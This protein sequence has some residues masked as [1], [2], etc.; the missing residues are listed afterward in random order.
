MIELKYILY[1]N[2]GSGNHGC[3]A[4]V[5][6][7]QEILGG[8]M[9]IHSK[10]PEED[11]KYGLGEFA[12]IVPA[13]SAVKKDFTYIKSYAKLK[14]FGNYTDMDGLAYL[15]TI[16]QENGKGRLALSVG[17]DNYCYSDQPFYAF[18]NR[19]YRKNGYKTVLWGCSI[20]PDVVENDKI[21]DDLKRY[22]LIVTREGITYD[23]LKKI[24]ANVVLAPD[25]AFYMNPEECDLDSRIADG[26]TVGINISPMILSNESQSGLAYNNYKALIRHILDNTD[27]NVALIPHVV[28]ASNDD[29]T[30]LSKLYDDF[31]KDDRLVLVEDHKAPE[32][33]YVISR[34]RFFVGARTHSTIAA[35]SSCVPTLVV[36]YSV[37]ARGIAR[38]LF[39]SEEN[40]VLPVQALKEENELTQAFLW[41][42]KNEE[43]IRSG[44]NRTMPEYKNIMTNV[45]KTMEEYYE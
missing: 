20:E 28:W 22:S 6:G 16:E 36:G 2:G 10:A 15:P 12:E 13:V 23:A 32:L 30:V 8:N 38:D 18:L 45:R 4:I 25:P 29:R 21:S 39:G 24:G 3:E 40:Y 35:Y 42:C 11:L 17:G 26:N 9:T 5:R 34:C 43:E 37:K 14:L 33:K 31:G 44:L 27:M 41:L 1:A 19:A 7:T